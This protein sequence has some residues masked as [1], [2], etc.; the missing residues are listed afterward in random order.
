MANAVITASAPG[1][2]LLCGEY[3]VLDGAPAVCMAVN[4]RAKVTIEATRADEHS[5]VAPGY[6]ERR[7]RFR[8]NDG[9][10]AWL[11]DGT[12][13]ELLQYA[14]RL[15]RPAPATG[16]DITLDSSAFFDAAA[17]GKIGL[18][19]SAALAVALA[20]ALDSMRPGD[21]PVGVAHRA[22]LD[23]QGGRG[24]G[25]DV[26]C[27][28]AGGLIVYEM[29]GRRSSRLEWPAGLE[30]RLFYS[31]IAAKTAAK[32]ERYEQNRNSS[33]KAAFRAAA[34]RMGDAWREG[35]SAA[36]LDACRDYVAALEKFSVDHDLGIF[37]AG[38][39][40]LAAAAKAKGLVYK[41]CGA[42]GGDVGI[43][44]ASD[45]GAIEDFTAGGLPAGFRALN[46]GID[47]NGVEIAR[48][49]L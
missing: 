18:G 32:I 35:S 6:S 44:F 19:S 21:D 38:H 2:V 1:K 13:F 5:V 27:S 30:C 3:A 22:H 25:V 11:D 43:A 23:L 40:E 31:G 28:A 47:L 9:E 37:D 4:A 34:L 29:D 12:G 45:A 14:W 8:D 17:S 41:P 7:V 36:I 10:I 42:G 26:A 15:T 16:L 20:A 24:S 48:N 33:S 49:T 46:F 39:A